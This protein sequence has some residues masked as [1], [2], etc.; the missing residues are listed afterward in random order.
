M[1]PPGKFQAVL[2]F[3]YWYMVMPDLSRHL[4]AVNQIIF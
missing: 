2:I 3:V 4:Q 1:K